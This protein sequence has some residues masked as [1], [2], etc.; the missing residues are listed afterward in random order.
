MPCAQY[1]I[2]PCRPEFD[3]MI[4]PSFSLVE[5]IVFGVTVFNLASVQTKTATEHEVG[6]G[7][8]N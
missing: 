5:P 2:D 6:E 7:K 3:R 8:R 1:L 4:S